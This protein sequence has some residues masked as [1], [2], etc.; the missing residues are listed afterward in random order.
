MR[1]GL[2]VIVLLTSILC[3][4]A[5]HASADSGDLTIVSQQEFVIYEE[6]EIQAWLTLN[7]RGTEQRSFTIPT[8]NN[9]PNGINSN[10][11]PIKSYSQKKTV[12]SHSYALRL[13][14]LASA[15]T[16]SQIP[17]PASGSNTLKNQTFIRL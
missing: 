17:H 3:P 5:G 4:L 8:P 9:L 11:F 14:G 6:Q 2:I 1:A 10:S 16:L 15:L 13:I 7:N 12:S